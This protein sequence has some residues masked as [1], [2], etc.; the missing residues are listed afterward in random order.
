MDPRDPRV[1]CAVAV[2]G[3]AGGVLRAALETW[4]PAGG[5]WPWATLLVNV[6]G[7][8]L[9]AWVAASPRARRRL[10]RPLVGTG[11]CGALTTFSTMQVELVGMLRHGHVAMAAAYAP[12]SIG[13]GLLAM[14]VVVRAVTVR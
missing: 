12:V 11:F 4:W 3:A 5:G 14:V 2:G 8:A 10:M 6:A 1:L 13:A 9:L 7:A